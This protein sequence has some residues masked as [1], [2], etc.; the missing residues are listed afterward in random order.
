[1]VKPRNT[2]GFDNYTWYVRATIRSPPSRWRTS[3][4]LPERRN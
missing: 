2:V 4:I 1:M 3:F